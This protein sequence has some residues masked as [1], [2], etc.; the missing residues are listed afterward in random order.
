MARYLRFL[1]IVLLVKASILETEYVA[2]NLKYLYEVLLILIA[3]EDPELG[4]V[5]ED[6]LFISLV[7]LK[8]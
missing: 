3:I 4:L 6:F 1:Y 8:R 7:I 2:R 5:A